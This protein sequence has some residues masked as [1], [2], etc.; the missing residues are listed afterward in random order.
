M[1]RIPVRVRA[2]LFVTSGDPAFGRGEP[3]GRERS[4]RA[5]GRGA[6][7]GL[8]SPGFRWFAGSPRV[9]SLISYSWTRTLDFSFALFLY[10]R[11][12]NW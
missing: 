10:H 11:L 12:V 8:R 6:G 3:G 2:V 1:C 9:A 7:P 4:W 5:P